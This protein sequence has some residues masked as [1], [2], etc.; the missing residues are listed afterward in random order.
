MSDYE[1]K[2]CGKCGKLLGTKTP[3]GFIIGDFI[4]SSK[5]PFNI[6]LI[7]F[8]CLDCDNS[9]YVKLEG[10]IIPLPVSES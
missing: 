1:V 8:K 5:S 4:L 9:V 7:D 2:V 3:D 6:H 10:E